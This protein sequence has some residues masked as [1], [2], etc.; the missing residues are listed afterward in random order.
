LRERLSTARLYLL[1]TPALC[2]ERDPLGVLSAALPHVDLVQVRIKTGD[3]P[4]AAR[5]LHDWTARVLALTRDSGLPVIVNDRPDVAQSLAAHGCAGVHLGQDDCPPRIARE[6]LGPEA[7]IGL[8]THSPAQVV[9]AL[10]EPIDYLGFGPVHATATKGYAHGLGA[11]AAWVAHLSAHV[12]LFPLGGIDAMNAGELSEIGRAAVSAAIL[13][14]RDPA[15]AARTLRE[16]L[17]P[18]E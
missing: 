11:E 7:L 10:D 1:F 2:G 6:L 17:E 13:S 12:P 8:S 3:A 16:L 15:A 18:T 14:A 5:E 4:T 9:R